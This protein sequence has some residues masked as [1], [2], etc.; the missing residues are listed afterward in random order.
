M[1][2]APK[3]VPPVHLPPLPLRPDPP[4]VDPSAEREADKRA[5][6][7]IGVLD[8][9]KDLPHVSKRLGI[10]VQHLV[11][12]GRTTIV[13]GCSDSKN[14][15]WRRTPLG[16]ANGMHYYLWWTPQGSPQTNGA[17]FG[18]R[19]SLFLRAVRHHDD[20]KVLAFGTSSD[21]HALGAQEIVAE[22]DGCFERP[23]TP[24]QDR[25]TG[26]DHAV[27]VV[28]GYPGSGKTMALWRAVES[29]HGD[30]TLYLTWSRDLADQARSRFVAFGSPDAS[31]EAR[32]FTTFLGVLCSK[33]V[34]R[35]SLAESRAMFRDAFEWWKIR[36]HLGPWKG[37]LDAL[38]AE[39][40]STLFG[41][42]V[43]GHFDCVPDG[44]R[45]S[46]DEYLKISDGGIGREGAVAAL[47]ILQRTDWARCFESV[48]PELAAAREALT[49]LL[50]GDVPSSLRDFDRIVVDEAQDLTLLEAAVIVQFCRRLASNG[51]HAPWLLMGYDDGQTVRPSGFHSGR[52]SDLLHRWFE[53][54]EEFGL[55]YNV[56]SPS[57]IAEVVER[58]SSL[59]T[60]I[61][62]GSRP[63]NQRNLQVEQEIDARLIY[64]AVPSQESASGLLKDLGDLDD[65]A[66]ITPEPS[67][68]EWVPRESR[69]AVLTPD[70]AKGLE[71]ASVCVLNP[72]RV[73]KRLNLGITAVDPLERQARRTAIDRLRVALSRAT[74]NLAF[75]DVQ[76]DDTEREQSIELLGNP[77]HFEFTDL[78]ELF[79]DSDATP[80]QRVLARVQD[81]RSLVEG[82]PLRA[83]DRALQA[84]RILGKPGQ[85][86]S[87][88]DDSIKLEA[89]SVVLGVAARRLVDGGPDFSGRDEV[90]SVAQR[91]ALEWGSKGTAAAF[92]QFESWTK[93]RKGQ[94]VKMLEAVMAL[95]D[96]DKKAIEAALPP[97][98]Q[99]LLAALRAS[100]DKASTAARFSRDV[101]AWLRMIGFVGNADKEARELRLRAFDTLIAAER[102][103][104]AGAVLRLVKPPDAACSG[105]LSEHLGRPAEAA[106]HYEKADK[107]A[108][109]L[110]TWRR[111]GEWEKAIVHA[112]GKEKKDLA[113]LISVEKV[114]GRRP[115]GI[116]N[117]M[118]TQERAKLTR[119]TKLP[120][121]KQSPKIPGPRQKVLGI[122]EQEELFGDSSE[123]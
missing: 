33:D 60:T 46:D 29:R 54:P 97:M 30:K 15:G 61:E 24:A 96:E 100:T 86:T 72:G 12:L 20:H 14:R 27:R 2:R 43:P 111:A 48:F 79:R 99:S 89:R 28:H 88:S 114:A 116:E 108:D 5:W 59:Y 10:V 13:K 110:R 103:R 22:S 23:W 101:Q 49:R 4:N 81:A 77:D 53:R 36:D 47:R 39:L 91:V 1:L 120:R 52:L 17:N 98:S 9:I 68:P 26:D 85:E 80:E 21:Y 83:W 123:D 73:L 19:G 119:L 62:K 117:R 74:E 8:D 64:V 41:C 40:R 56:R 55:E 90:A 65:V 94:P 115:S 7:H 102:V 34:I 3:S 113:W 95:E 69:N 67:V 25:F 93:V 6:L 37:D 84:I 82:S 63:T 57:V 92:K 71:Y 42:A 31:I 44:G 122:P 18:G 112:R 105:L 75:V 32:D 109:A 104:D 38:H 45:L 16:G 11:A 76:A 51:S 87:I 66:V 50:E 58:A 70:A 106:Q 78:V 107:P 121:A 118:T 35:Q